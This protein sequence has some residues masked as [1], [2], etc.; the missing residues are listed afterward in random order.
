MWTGWG[1]GIGVLLWTGGL[2]V[3]IPVVSGGISLPAFVLKSAPTSH[4]II[5]TSNTKFRAPSPPA[6][7]AK[8]AVGHTP[9]RSRSRSGTSGG[10]ALD[11]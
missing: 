10:P 7:S 8:A 9:E 6:G 5:K 3:E 11:E 2:S 4:D 1:P